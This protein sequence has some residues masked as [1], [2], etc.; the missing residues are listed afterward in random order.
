[1]SDLPESQY[2]EFRDGLVELLPAMVAAAPIALL[3]GAIATGK[4]LSP[5][6]VTLSSALVF[7]GGAQLAAIELWTV[8]VPIAALVLSTVLIN[9]RYILMSASLAPKVAHLPFG[10]RLLGFHALADENWALAER[11]AASRRLTAAYFFGSGAVFWV[12]WV[13][14]SWAGTVLGPLL[15]DPRRFGA[16]F[17]FTAI[18][19]GLVAGF[20]T[21]RRAGIVVVASAAAATAAHL[22]F[23]SPWH[24][25]AGAF[26]GM[27]AAVLAWRADAEG[28]PA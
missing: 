9:A 17:A 20:L 27:A 3:Y 2:A 5:L 7:A 4:G 8:P 25:L 26:A 24:V 6:E 22:A 10:A 15:G 28:E 13:A 1:M 16:D 12:N 14:W 19:I 21:T 23:G 18:F 11:R